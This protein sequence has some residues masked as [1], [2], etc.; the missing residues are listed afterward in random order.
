MRG[1]KLHEVVRE[2]VMFEIMSDMC[3][4]RQRICL[5]GWC[6]KNACRST[7]AWP[8]KTVLLT[9]HATITSFFCCCYLTLSAA[10]C[11]LEKQGDVKASRRRRKKKKMHLFAQHPFPSPPPPK[12]PDFKSFEGRKEERK[13]FILAYKFLSAFSGIVG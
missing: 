2:S 4:M 10:H 7:S 8:K 11:L 12:E 1:A 9:N 5:V 13:S 3:L 6:S